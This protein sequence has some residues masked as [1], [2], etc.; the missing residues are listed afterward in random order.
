YTCH[1]PFIRMWVC[2]TSPDENRINGCLARASTSATVAPSNRSVAPPRSRLR[3]P[4]IV[5]PPSHR[6]RLTAVRK[7]VSPSGVADEPL[8]RGH[9]RRRPQQRLELIRVPLHGQ[10][11]EA[12]ALQQ[13]TKGL[14]GGLFPAAVT[15][16]QRE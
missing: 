15:R 3:T 2:T 7:M 14:D 5:R 13:P 6:R 12:P 1:A 9:E 8:R 10:L 4:V 16:P 11:G